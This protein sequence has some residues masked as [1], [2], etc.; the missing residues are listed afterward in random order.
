MQDSGETCSWKLLLLVQ[1][2]DHSNMTGHLLAGHEAQG[3]LFLSLTGIRYVTFTLTL[4]FHQIAQRE[5]LTYLKV[6][7]ACSLIL[8][9][10]SKNPILQKKLVVTSWKHK[11]GN[12]FSK[13]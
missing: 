8:I 2:I 12:N 1:L 10:S 13:D 3:G 9:F 5:Y 4:A 7:I 6:E 11:F